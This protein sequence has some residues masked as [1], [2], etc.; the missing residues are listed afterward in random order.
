MKNVKNYLL[1]NTD[2]MMDIVNELN[3]WDDSLDHL[4]AYDN[5]DEFFEVFFE[6]RPAEVAKAIHFGDFNYNDDYIRF[7]GYGNLETLTER[8]LVQEMRD[9]IDEIVDLLLT[10]KDNIYIDDD[11][12]KGLLEEEEE[13]GEQEQEKEQEQEQEQSV[14]ADEVLCICVCVCVCVCL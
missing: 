4:R 7:N 9:N 3:N 13:E 11:E 6:R 5:D 10:N 8:Q 2:V 12:L 1:E 14:S